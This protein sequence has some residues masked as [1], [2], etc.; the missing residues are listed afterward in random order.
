MIYT[1]KGKQYLHKNLKHSPTLLVHLFLTVHEKNIARSEHV[2]KLVKDVNII[3]II[4][5]VR[6]RYQYGNIIIC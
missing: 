3:V 6:F 2:K 5:F 1:V 4:I